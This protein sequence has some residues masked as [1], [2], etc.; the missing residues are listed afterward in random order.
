MKKPRKIPRDRAAGATGVDGTR[1]LDVT[2]MSRGEVALHFAP[3]GF[4]VHLG[5]EFLGDLRRPLGFIQALRLLGSSEEIERRLKEVEQAEISNTQLHDAMGQLWP[6]AERETTANCLGRLRER[7]R[8]AK[9]HMVVMENQLETYGWRFNPKTRKV[10]RIAG[11]KGPD[12]L[13]EIVWKIYQERYKNKKNTT[14][15]RR[16]IARL[17]APYFDADELDTRGRT[18]APIY[19]AIYNRKYRERKNSL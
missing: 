18:G 14:I 19:A 16:E 15:V 8:E 4:G 5:P 7:L 3:L 2:K 9:K 11:H 6:V 17:L 10:S 1:T 13:A 12:L